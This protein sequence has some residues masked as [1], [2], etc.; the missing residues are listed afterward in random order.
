MTDSRPLR[1]I[2][3]VFHDDDDNRHPEEEIEGRDGGLWDFAVS[4]DDSELDGEEE[5]AVRQDSYL[6]RGTAAKQ[7]Q[8]QPQPAIRTFDVKLRRM[9]GENVAEPQ[10]SVEIDVYFEEHTDVLTRREES[11]SPPA[12]D[13]ASATGRTYDDITKSPPP[14]LRCV[15]SPLSSLPPVLRCTAASLPRFLS[16]T[17]RG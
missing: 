1:A 2:D 15:V 4:D 9:L 5:E 17:S 11:P 14:H 16:P 7:A 10:P 3:V 13:D 6:R 8:P 12:P